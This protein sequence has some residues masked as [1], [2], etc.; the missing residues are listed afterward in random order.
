[1]T[2]YNELEVGALRITTHLEQGHKNIA[3]HALH[4]CRVDVI[5]T[6]LPVQFIVGSY[7]AHLTIAK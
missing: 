7:K 6:M 3:I 1:M 2:D 4:A 5:T